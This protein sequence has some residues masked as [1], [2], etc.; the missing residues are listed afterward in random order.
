[1]GERSLLIKKE[2]GIRSIQKRNFILIKI[3]PLLNVEGFL[4]LEEIFIIMKES[5][6]P[7]NISQ[8]ILKIK[9]KKITIAD[10]SKCI[11][12]LKRNNYQKLFLFRSFFNPTSL[13]F[14]NLVN[15]YNLDIE[16]RNIIFYGLGIIESKLKTELAYYH[17]LKDNNHGYLNSDYFFDKNFHSLFIKEIVKELN[18]PKKQ[19]EMIKNHF[20]KYDDDPPLY[21]IIEIFSFGQ[22]SKF[23][24]N[25]LNTDKKALSKENYD[26]IDIFILKSWFIF[27]VEIRNAC[28]HGTPLLT[29]KIL[30]PPQ[31]LKN[32][33]WDPIENTDIRILF[34]GM[35]TVIN[36]STEFDKVKIKLIDS[37]KSFNDLYSHSKLASMLSFLETL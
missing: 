15:L 17:V 25:M 14:E 3:C 20:N 1:M 9:S 10:E 32:S 19:P 8:Q 31:K 4:S 2:S 7:L 37:L 13:T 26:R 34:L 28:A 21:K 30:Y 11:A 18:I 6:P 5:K 33:T 29:K 35:K 16:I 12:F 27:L 36:D 23:Y 24:S 22:I